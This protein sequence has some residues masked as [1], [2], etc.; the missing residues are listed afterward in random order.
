MYEYQ[1]QWENNETV[2]NGENTTFTQSDM[3]IFRA[4]AAFAKTSNTENTFHSIP[5]EN[6]PCTHVHTYTQTY[7]Y[8]W[9]KQD[10]KENRKRPNNRTIRPL[11][12]VVLHVIVVGL[13]YCC[14]FW[15]RLFLKRSN[16]QWWCIL[17]TYFYYQLFSY[18]YYFRLF[19]YSN[20]YSHSKKNTHNHSVY[21]TLIT[22]K[23]TQT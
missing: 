20:K 19:H 10:Q 12:H 6:F 21:F 8:H 2:L 13:L 3:L 15:F 17:L 1:Y 11:F 9:D 7:T 18:F 22:C 4:C 16:K 5:M 14:C 23:L